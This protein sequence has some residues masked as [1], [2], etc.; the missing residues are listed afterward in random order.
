MTAEALAVAMID[1]VARHG[2]TGASVAR[3]LERAGASRRAF[4]RHYAGREDCFL[5]AYRCAAAEIGGRLREAI[6]EST[7][8]ERPEATIAALLGAIEQR[9]ALARV[10]LVEALGACPAVRAEHERQLHGIE[11]A[12]ERFLSAPE[13]PTLQAPAVAL[14]GGI[15]GVLCARVLLGP[16]ERG[17]DSASLAAWVRSFERDDARGLV[18]TPLDRLGL[19]AS[20]TYGGPGQGAEIQLLPRGRSALAPSMASNARR[21]RILAATMRQTA[22]RGYGNLTVAHIVADARVPR[23]AFYAHFAGKQEAFL[24]AQTLG[25]RESTAAAAAEFVTG[26][27]WPERVW[28]GLAALLDYLA[29][30]PD[31]ARLCLLEAP[32]A[33]PAPAARICENRGAYA[34][35]L[36]EGYQ[37][38]TH[39]WPPAPL[40]SEATIAA[41]E[42]VVR[43][44]LLRG[45][46]DR[47]REALP[48]CAY[49]ALAPFIG[50]EA[51]LDWVSERARAAA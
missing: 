44:Y 3:V 13:A 47:V 30:H 14:V 43:L 37:Q 51:A 2:Y 34:I 20:L 17:E 18:G 7:P 11:G 15:C 25:L 16:D 42:A 40:G 35:F 8:G 50:P 28:L 38:R 5:A 39:P 19:P 23:S 45:L 33:G 1:V 26:R 27:S 32:A 29:A 46:A 22:A 9:P 6:R 41:I 4:Y 21:A 48:Q 31:L 49:I 10:L 24:A 12:V 36:A